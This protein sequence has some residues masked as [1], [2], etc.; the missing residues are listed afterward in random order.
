[1]RYS[2]EECADLCYLRVFCRATSSGFGVS[3]AKEDGG[4]EE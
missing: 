1:M 3:L 4:K 2:I